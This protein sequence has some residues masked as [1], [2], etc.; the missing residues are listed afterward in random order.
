MDKDFG[1]F[2][3]VI[4]LAF[5][6]MAFIIG[7]KIGNIEG[8]RIGLVEGFS[9]AKLTPIPGGATFS[10]TDRSKGTTESFFLTQKEEDYIAKVKK[11]K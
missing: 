2:I 9:T 3:I 1:I 7:A 6:L 5:L 10:Y 8:E 11:E 4:F